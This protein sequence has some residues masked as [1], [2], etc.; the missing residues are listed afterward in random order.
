MSK[1]QY[2]PLVHL[3]PYVAYMVFALCLGL[4][5]HT[6]ECHGP[7]P[8]L[9]RLYQLIPE[10]RVLSDVTYIAY[11][12]FAFVLGRERVCDNYKYDLLLDNDP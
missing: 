1:C 9:Y 2:V 3:V 8:R 11:M 6:C 4:E 10:T 12:V 7:S 5:C